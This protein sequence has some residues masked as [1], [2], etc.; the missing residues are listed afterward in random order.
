M[1]WEQDVHVIAMLTTFSGKDTREQFRCPQYVPANVRQNSQ[2]GNMSVTLETRDLYDG[3]CVNTITVVHTPTGHS[4]I[5]HHL[6]V[7][8]LEKESMLRKD[9]GSR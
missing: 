4:R 1:A 6:Q 7:I 2:F 5:I 3:F 9:D 8:V